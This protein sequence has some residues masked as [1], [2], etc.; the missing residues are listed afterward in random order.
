MP[1]L[2]YDVI[3]MLL[4]LAGPAAFVCLLLAGIALRKE[5]GTVFWVGGGFS[6]HMTWAV[7]FLAL[8]PTLIWFQFLGAPVFFPPGPAISNAWLASVQ[9]GISTFVSTFVVARITPI[10]AGYFVLRS[11]LDT[12]SGTGPLPSILSAM[13][14]LA[15]SSTHA[16]IDG[17]TPDADRFSIS[18]GLA[19]MWNYVASRIFPIAAGLAV[20]G[21]IVCFAFNRSGYLRLIACAGGFLTVS[22]LWVL[23][24][25]MM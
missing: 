8:E 19:A 11:V 20:C 14:L 10:V 16:L 25:R 9:S 6:R 18:F 17:W 15:I 13:F 24:N 3:R 2:L 23:I 7:V 5:G 1:S 22:A 12:T 4:L 21:A